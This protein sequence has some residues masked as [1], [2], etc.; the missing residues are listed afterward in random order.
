M[1]TPDAV[2]GDVHPLLAR[3]GGRRHGAVEIDGGAVEEVV[4]LLSPD[5]L[6]RVVDRV[7]QRF[8]VP[9]PEAAAEVAGRG[10][11]RDAPRPQG[12]EVVLVVAAQFDVLQTDAVAQGVVGEVEHVIGFVI[13]Q[14]Q[15]EQMQTLID[16]LD[17][18]VAS[19][20]QMHGADAAAVDAAPFGRHFVINVAGSELRFEAEREIL[21]IEAT[22]DAALASREPVRE[23]GT[24]LKSFRD[25]DVWQSGNYSNTTNHRR[26]SGFFRPATRES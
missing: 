7:G 8:D 10:R 22:L 21:L 14:V 16:R 17:Q 25:C 9:R 23:N 11:V 6:A 13:G 2:V 15:L 18:T 12:I 1:V 5:A 4:G 26:I 3:A 24:H 19:R 20:Q